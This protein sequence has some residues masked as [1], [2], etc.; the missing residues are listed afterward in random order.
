MWKNDR[1]KEGKKMNE[2]KRTRE[3][4]RKRACE[5]YHCMVEFLYKLCSRGFDKV[6]ATVYLI[7]ILMS[8]THTH[9]PPSMCEGGSGGSGDG[10]TAVVFIVC[11]RFKC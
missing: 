9:S 10:A 11:T 8:T 2:R 6:F 7:S 4:L 5:K 3:R 1:K